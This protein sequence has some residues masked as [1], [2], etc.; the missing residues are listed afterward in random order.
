M[1]FS[2][3]RNTLPDEAGVGFEP[4]TLRFHAKYWLDVIF[5]KQ[6]N[7]DIGVRYLLFITN[8]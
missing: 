1:S 2:K 7:L 4:M 3:G 8:D 5:L 6:N